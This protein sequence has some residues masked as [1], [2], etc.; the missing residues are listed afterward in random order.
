MRLGLRYYAET[1]KQQLSDQ[2][3]KQMLLRV[4]C[5]STVGAS[6]RC[7]AV[8]FSV[9]AGFRFAAPALMAGNVGL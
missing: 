1:A 5:D 6:T 7:D 3:V 8:E 2:L 4:M 9:L